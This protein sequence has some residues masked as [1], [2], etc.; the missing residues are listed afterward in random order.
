MTKKKKPEPILQLADGREGVRRYQTSVWYDGRMT[1]PSPWTGRGFPKLEEGSIRA[2]GNLVMNGLAAK[3]QCFDRVAG[4]VEWTV[5]K[6]P[7][8]RGTHVY[9]PI[10]E[11]GDPDSPTRR[12]RA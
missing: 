2:A 10:I 8:V 9:T 11:R 1:D 12:R 6:G 7:R 5:K 4:R 3:V